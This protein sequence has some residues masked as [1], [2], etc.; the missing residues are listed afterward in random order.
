MLAEER[1]TYG[2]IEV[3]LSS[4]LANA[5]VIEVIPCWAAEHASSHFPKG[6]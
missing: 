6:H 5:Q 1:G 2:S 3:G 4:V